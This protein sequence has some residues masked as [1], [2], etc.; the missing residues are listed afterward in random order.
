MLA[1]EQCSSSK[2]RGRLAVV[3]SPGWILPTKREKNSTVSCGRGC[4]S[5]MAGAG[6]GIAPDGLRCQANG[7]KLRMECLNDV[8]Q[9][10]WLHHCWGISV[11]IMSG[12]PG[13]PAGVLDVLKVCRRGR[14]SERDLQLSGG[15]KGCS[16][17]L[18]VVS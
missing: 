13:K 6:S 17:L 12:V 11:L 8:T 14:E 15:Q 7:R 5:N 16:G 9:T 4:F 18:P 10:S 2:K 3:V 1:Q